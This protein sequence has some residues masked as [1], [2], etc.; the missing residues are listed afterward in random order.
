MFKNDV[1]P[2]PVNNQILLLCAD[3]TTCFLK[4]MTGIN[5]GKLK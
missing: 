2:V 5:V 4:T 3:N 1:K